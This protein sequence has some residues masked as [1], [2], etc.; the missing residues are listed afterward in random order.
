MFELGRQTSYLYKA[1]FLTLRDLKEWAGVQTGPGCMGARVYT[2]DQHSSKH[3]AGFVPDL[4][5]SEHLIPL[6]AAD[7]F[8]LS[9]YYRKSFYKFD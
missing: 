4:E 8:F 1:Y 6:E 5:R 9:P 3:L 7:G 2:K